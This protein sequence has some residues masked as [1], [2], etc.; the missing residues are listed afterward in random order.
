MHYPAAGQGLNTGV[1]DAVNLGW[2][3]ATPTPSVVGE[4]ITFGV[5]RFAY[6]VLS[7]VP[8]LFVSADHATLRPPGLLRI[9]HL[10]P[11]G[12]VRHRHP[13][14]AT[15]RRIGLAGQ[16]LHGRP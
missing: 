13:G 1:Q 14:L 3:L 5:E 16:R 7:C 12:R 4:G 11:G 2:N 15:L 6:A 8:E 10:R 9:C